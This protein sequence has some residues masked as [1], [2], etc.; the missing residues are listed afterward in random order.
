MVGITGALAMDNA[1][2]SDDIDLLI[3]TQKNR[4]WL[5]RLIVTMVLEIIGRRR[6]PNHKN[7]KDKICLNLY[8]DEANWQLSKAKKSLFTAHELIQLKPV[9]N[10]NNTYEKFILR[11]YWLAN[12]LPNSLEVQKLKN[13]DI[14]IRTKE[15]IV[16]NLIFN[17]LEAL[18]YKIQALFMKTKITSE[19]IGPYYAFFHPNNQTE[20]VLRKYHQKLNKYAYG[21]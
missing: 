13:E 12:Y 11:N 1:R 9:L 19:V 17:T 3:I 7:I 6:R 5:T 14:R 10:R 2:K 4:L 20:T 15:V 16:K 21:K 8:L 18:A